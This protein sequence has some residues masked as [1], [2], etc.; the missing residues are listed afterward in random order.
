M[1]NFD[2]SSPKVKV[3]TATGQSQ[4]STGTGDL[5]LPQL[6]SGFL[7]TGHILPGFRHT[8]IGVGPFFYTDCTVTFTSAAVIVR[9]ARGMPVLT[10]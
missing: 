9:D 7:I 5:N 4:Q 2:Y 1:V 3:G 8:L 6:P 10:G